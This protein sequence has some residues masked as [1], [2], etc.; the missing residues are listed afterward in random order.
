MKTCFAP[1]ERAEKK[2]LIIEIEI[3]S[4]NPV[5]SGLLSS[6]SG[7]LVVLDEH[8]QIVAFNGAFLKMLGINNPAKTLGLRPGEALNCI[9]AHEEPAGCG[10]TSL[11][12]TCGAAVAIVSSMGQ[13]KPVERICALTVKKGDKLID[14]AMLVRSHPIKI[15]Q[16]RF[17]LLFLQ[18][19]T[20]AQQQAALERTFFHD[21][22]NMLN[23][24]VSASELLI[25]NDSSELAGTIHDTALRLTKEVAIQRHLSQDR[26][27]AYPP[28]WQTVTT[29]Q[30]LNELRLFFDNHP[31]AHKKNIA[32]SEKN[33]EV[34]IKTDLS[35]LLRVLCNM[36]LNALE[37]T[38]ESGVVRIWIEQGGDALSFCVWNAQEIPQE[39][40]KRIF[41]RNFSTKDQPGRGVGTFSMKLFG[42]KILGGRVSFTTSKEDGT[43]FTFTLSL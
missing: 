25:E 11:C 15:D 4:R 39:L 18:D 21:I 26:F 36:T 27:S 17:L 22:N 42:E 33:P 35:L 1:A 14:L 8:R 37:S 34:P 3:V 40:T 41:Q 20:Q 43:V 24:L 19:I 2:E 30:V 32:F 9:H 7:L 10:T 5:M 28:V 29:G 16:K 23:M 38:D 31:A 12:S 13:D 6:I